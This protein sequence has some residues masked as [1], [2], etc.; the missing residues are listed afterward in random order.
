LLYGVDLVITV[1]ETVIA[2][3]AARHWPAGVG[4]AGSLFPHLLPQAL[5]LG[6]RE[7]RL[8]TIAADV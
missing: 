7:L 2:A 1:I 6:F 4:G 5:G 8:K 3:R